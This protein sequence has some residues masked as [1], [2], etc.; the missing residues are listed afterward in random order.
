MDHIEPKPE[1]GEERWHCFDLLLSAEPDHDLMWQLIKPEAL[2]FDGFSFED[3]DTLAHC[4]VAQSDVTLLEAINRGITQIRLVGVD[5][6]EV[7]AGEPVPIEIVAWRM[8]FS[9]AYVQALR[10]D[11]LGPGGFPAPDEYDDYHWPD[12]VS[13]FVEHFNPEL[14]N[15]YDDGITR[16]NESLKEVVPYVE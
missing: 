3:G 14:A 1:G 6:I 9:E 4:V 8:G 13:W 12:V 11:L 7:R 10:H 15:Q 2:L 16:A 5:V